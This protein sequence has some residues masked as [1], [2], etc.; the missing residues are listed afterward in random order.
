MGS[1]DSSPGNLVS[2]QIIVAAG[3]IAL[4]FASGAVLAWI[5]RC[6]SRAKIA[7]ARLD[8]YIPVRPSAPHEQPP[9]DSPVSD[10]ADEP[11]AAVRSGAERRRHPRLDFF[12]SQWIAPFSGGALP[13]Q[14][15][16]LEVR[17]LDVS[18]S[19]FSFAT[20]ER[21]DFRSIIIRFQVGG[22]PMYLTA[23]IVDCR[24]YDAA[25]VSSFRVGCE[26]TGRFVSDHI[27][28]PIG[29]E[30]SEASPTL[31]GLIPPDASLGP[32]LQQK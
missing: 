18:T 29:C 10:D 8:C 17:C 25:G 2:L 21:P 7:S 27:S 14:A 30:L 9:G 11:P 13:E 23:R 15:V 19:G 3:S 1:S 28:L 16:F 5:L 32:A 4:G 22:A 20:S 31:A 26:F 24:P 12:G 6:R